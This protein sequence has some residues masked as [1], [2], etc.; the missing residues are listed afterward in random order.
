MELL[1][2]FREQAVARGLIPEDAELTAENVFPLVRDMDYQRA[3]SREPADIIREWRGTC[4]G[5]HYVLNTLFEEL[6][7][8][9]RLMMCTHEFTQENSEH[10]SR[11]LL[12][13]LSAGPIPDVHTF[14]RLEVENGW[15]D[16]DA[17]WPLHTREIGMP[18][19]ERF[20]LGVSMTLACDPIEIFYVPD[21]SDPQDFKNDLIESHCAGQF[22]SRDQFIRDMSKWLLESSSRH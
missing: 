12:V 20:E 15:M 21:D 5:K 3:S 18:V 7:Y 14:L 19:N 1:P 13:Q 11:S 9:T 6:G 22:R 16:V 8:E 10:F 2:I 17:T 4:S